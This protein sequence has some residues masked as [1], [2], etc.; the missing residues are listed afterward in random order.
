MY[1]SPVIAES[2]Q[3][4][5]NC[6]GTFQRYHLAL[7]HNPNAKKVLFGKNFK[8]ARFLNLQRCSNESNARTGTMAPP[9][10]EEGIFSHGNGSGT[11]I[12]DIPKYGR[13]VTDCAKMRIFADLITRLH[14][15]KHRCL[16]FCQMTR[17][18]DILED[19]LTWKKMSFFRMDGSTS[20]QD[21]RYMVDEYQRNDT[22]FCFLLSTR[23]GGLGINLIAADTVIF[24]DNDWNPTMDEQATDRAHRIGQTKPVT[25]Y[26]IL[27]KGTVEEKIVKRAKQKQNVQSTVYGDTFKLKDVVQLVMDDE[28]GAD[29]DG[30]GA[31]F[32]KQ[33]RQRGGGGKKKESVV[34]ESPVKAGG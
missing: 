2:V 31:S 33:K 9:L 17:M 32:I 4:E 11:N 12:V 29:A 10:L 6:S 23:A 27:T 13:L 20:I 18:L 26:R 25:V 8:P 21:R 5:V 15:E 14:V 30:G 19:F 1:V 28:V 16:V 24:Y 34:K 22:T 3:L 7:K